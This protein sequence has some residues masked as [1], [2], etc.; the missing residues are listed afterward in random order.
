LIQPPISEA[1]SLE[2]IESKAARIAE[3]MD[4][5]KNER[6]VALDLRGVADFTDCFVIASVFSASQRKATINR[7]LERLKPLS[8]RPVAPVEDESPRWAIVDY[9]DVVV[10]LFD[11]E[12]RALYRLEDLWGDAQPIAWQSRSSV[13]EA[14]GW[15]A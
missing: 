12:A 10:H 13:A 5:M 8:I 14:V 6:I 2:P 1:Q 9:G 3:I 11:P 7:L 4:E 15:D